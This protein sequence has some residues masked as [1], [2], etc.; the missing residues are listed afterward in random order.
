MQKKL[1]IIASFYLFYYS[2]GLRVSEVVRL[3][4]DDLDGKRKLIHLYFCSC[5]EAFFCNSFI[6]GR[7]RP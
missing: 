4:V 6:R 2:A 7:Y 1:A 5:I 3:K